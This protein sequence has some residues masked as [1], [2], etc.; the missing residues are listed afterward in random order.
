MNTNT[1]TSTTATA[2][3]IQFANAIDVARWRLCVGC[4]AC[5]YACPEK[6]LQMV[7]RQSEGLRPAWKPGIGAGEDEASASADADADANANA[8]ANANTLAVACQ[9]CT[10]CVDVCPGLGIDHP[11]PR[12]DA[13]WINELTQS[14][15]PVLEVWEGHATD[16][17]LRRDGSS[18]GLSS[19]LALYCIEQAGMQGLVHVASDDQVQYTSRSVFNQNRAAILAA[20]GSR[21]APASPCDHL[22]AIEDAGGPCVFIGKPCDVQGLRKAQAM[23]PGLDANVG[24]AIGIFCAGTP[25]TQG[26]L[27]LL[28]QH[29]VNP[30]DVAELRY[31]GR[32]WPGSFAVRLKESNT[33]N[34]LATYAEAW[35][36]LQRYRPYRCHLCPDG[37]SEFADI[38]CGDPWYREIQADEAGL[39][40]VVV[41]TQRGRDIVRAAMAAGCVALTPVKPTVMQMS[42]KELQYKRGAIWG[43]LLTMRA[44]GVPAPQFDGFSLAQNWL[45]IPFRQQLRS[46]IGT[47]RRVLGRG[48][49]RPASHPGGVN[50]S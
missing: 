22:Q 40:L 31:R 46:F 14:W 4:G 30:D 28:R 9:D 5:T 24:L 43:R 15:G 17:A 12:E 41:R 47:A 6:K 37:T 34:E 2:K 49:R 20:T 25:S 35:G 26:T 36:F 16:P 7:D 50:P 21:Y 23:R 48:Y 32:G 10:D 29:G 45:R 42:Q 38:A 19:A 44:L 39:S 8:N 27:D 11:P 3:T 18:G 1:S 33:W 13:A